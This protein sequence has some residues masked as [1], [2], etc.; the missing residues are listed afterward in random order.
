M[1]I[2]RA[3]MEADLQRDRFE[4]RLRHFVREW[5]PDNDR[6]RYE[7]QSQLCGLMRD[8]M[9]SQSAVIS[10]WLEMHAAQN[11]LMMAL[12]PL[13]VIFEKPEKK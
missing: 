9:Q 2:D 8:A 10:Y 4:H 12:Q 11:F 6:D 3:K 1:S 5:A 13:N 7:M